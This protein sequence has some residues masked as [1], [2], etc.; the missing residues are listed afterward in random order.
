MRVLVVRLNLMIPGCRSL[1]ERRGVLEP[2]KNNL[3]RKINLS[4]SEVKPR[5]IH[6][7]AS[8]GMAAVVDNTA[9]GDAQLRRIEAI[10]ERE[11][12]VVP[13]EQEVEYW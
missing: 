4:V 5:D 3:R 11:H 6:D 2:L 10:V 9:D 1:K 8:L 13:L 12:M 7:R